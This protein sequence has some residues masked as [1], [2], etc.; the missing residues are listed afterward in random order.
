MVPRFIGLPLGSMAS[1]ETLTPVA[2][3][4][5]GF[6]IYTYSIHAVWLSSETAET[7]SG[8]RK[9]CADCLVP[10]EMSVTVPWIVK[11]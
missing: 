1:I 5:F 6:C 7:P 8:K 10:G 2:F 3:V 4:G 9:D 11:P